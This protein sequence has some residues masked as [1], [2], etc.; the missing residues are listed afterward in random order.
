MRSFQPA[1]FLGDERRWSDGFRSMTDDDV[2][3]KI[4]R[5]AGRPLP[6]RALQGRLVPACA[7][8][9]VLDE[10]ENRRLVVELPLPRRR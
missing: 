3:S 5:G 7:P 4:G 6:F 2:V 8:H 9:S 1:A 10:A